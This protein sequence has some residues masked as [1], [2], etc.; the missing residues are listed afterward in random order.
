M[1]NKCFIMFVIV[2]CYS[3]LLM[4]HDAASVPDELEAGVEVEDQVNSAA[5]RS[6]VLTTPGCTHCTLYSVYR[7]EPDTGAPP[8]SVAVINLSVLVFG[9]ISPRL[10]TSIRSIGYRC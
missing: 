10:L 3:D 1:C 2:G 9:K 7:A 8:L 5:A 6:Y 4:L